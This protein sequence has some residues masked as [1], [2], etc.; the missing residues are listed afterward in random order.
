MCNTDCRLVDCCVFTKKHESH[1]MAILVIV[2]GGRL[3]SFIKK[4][5]DS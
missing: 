2:G 4:T 5:P 1:A 3:A